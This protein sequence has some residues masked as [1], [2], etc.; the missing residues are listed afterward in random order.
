MIK[1]CK[2]AHF[3]QRKAADVGQ[4]L[5]ELVLPVRIQFSGGQRQKLG[6]SMLNDL[7]LKF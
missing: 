7:G 3:L 1:R 6:G 5:T 4:Y 2:Q